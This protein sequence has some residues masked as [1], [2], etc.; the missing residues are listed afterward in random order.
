[1][2][3]RLAEVMAVL[4]DAY[5]PGLAHDWDSVVLVCGDPG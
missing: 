3:V 5:P 4:D 1:M 2:S